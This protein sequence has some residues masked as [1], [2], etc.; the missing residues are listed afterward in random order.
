MLRRRPAL[1]S[2]RAFG[3]GE[4]RVGV[5]RNLALACPAPARQAP[6]SAATAVAPA[7]GHPAAPAQTATPR[8]SRRTRL[9]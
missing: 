1:A 6:T 2:A 8:L 7:C 4:L 3:R 5:V 9:G